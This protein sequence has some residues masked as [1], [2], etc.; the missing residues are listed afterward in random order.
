MH[1]PARHTAARMA[2]ARKHKDHA[3]GL[4][5]VPGALGADV[6]DMPVHSL[7]TYG[8]LP[9]QEIV[10]GTVGQY[11]TLRHDTTNY[12]CFAHCIILVL[13]SIQSLDPGVTIGLEKLLGA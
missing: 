13:R 6:E 11:L 4:E 8:S 2:A 9:H 10:F 12:E 5:I 3:R 1:H 7:R